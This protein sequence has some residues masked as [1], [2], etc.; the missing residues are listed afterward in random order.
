METGYLLIDAESAPDLAQQV[1]KK[2][3]DGW[4]CQG[5]VAVMLSPH[6]K[7]AWFYQAMIKRQVNPQ[8]FEL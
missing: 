1:S 2:Q 6:G 5:G 7:E 3:L 4:L 8:G